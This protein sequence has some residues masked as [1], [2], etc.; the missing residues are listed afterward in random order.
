MVLKAM[1]EPKEKK[2]INSCSTTPST[3]EQLLMEIRDNFTK[4]TINKY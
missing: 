2:E 1:K 4:I 3:Q